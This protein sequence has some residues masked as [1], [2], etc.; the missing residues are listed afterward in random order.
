MEDI[1]SK[2]NVEIEAKYGVK[3]GV[4]KMNNSMFY[5]ELRDA[6]KSNS[7]GNYGLCHTCPPNIG[8]AEE[9]IKMV[10]SYKIFIAFQHIY[11]L[12]DSYDYE[13][14]V[15]GQ[16]KFKIVMSDVAD[17]AR[18]TF[19]DP[20]ILGAGGCQICERCTAKDGL[21]CRFP[22]KALSSLEANCIQVSQFSE[23]CGMK[24]INGQ[25]TVTYFGGIFLNEDY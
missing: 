9:C 15:E 10:Q 6:C 21:P 22:D 4:S 25:N 1:I 13:G 14:M 12:D 11:E 23:L 3:C 19:N 18:Q 20:L 5:A 17:L 24:Y 2:F 16:R 8:D 7:C